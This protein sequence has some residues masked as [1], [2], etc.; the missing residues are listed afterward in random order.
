MVGVIPGREPGAVVVGAHHDTKDGIP[1][2]VGANDGASGVAVVLELAR[3]LPRRLHG[4][5]LHLALFDAEEAR[6]DRS[7]EIDGTRG[8]RQYVAYA[9]AGGRQGSP[10]LEQI[11]AMVLFD[12]VG[13]CDLQIPREANS[14]RSLYG[15]FADAARGRSGSPAPFEG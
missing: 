4:P 3:A 10:P 7:F 2:F 9:L 12:M 13:D 15:A 5:S 6:G 14:D 8:S 1:G 11:Q